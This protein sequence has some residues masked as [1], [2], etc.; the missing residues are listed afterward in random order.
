MAEVEPVKPGIEAVERVTLGI[1]IEP[2]LS[3]VNSLLEAVRRLAGDMTERAG[4]AV[5]WTPPDAYAA[6]LAT[7]LA[8]RAAAEAIVDRM[9]AALRETEECP[10][11]LAP[12][13]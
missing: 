13:G 8:P 6:P 5:V 1:V 2:P 3:V 10:V 12:L 9:R 11:Q 7:G 4:T